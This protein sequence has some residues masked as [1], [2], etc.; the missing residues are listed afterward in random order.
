MPTTSRPCSGI[1]G[2]VTETPPWA[3]AA[4]L[5]AG[6]AV[7][8]AIHVAVTIDQRGSRVVDAYESYWHKATG[9]LFAP[10]DLERG[11]RLLVDCGLVEE[12]QGTLYP[13][14]ELQQILAG[15]FDDVVAAIYGRAVTYQQETAD[16]S[17][18]EA[19]AELEELIPDPARRE[20]LLLALARRF[21]DTQRRLIGAIGEE[22]VVSVLRAELNGLGYP[23][24]AR[25]VRH[26]S[27]ESD[28][29]G[30]DI[31]APRIGG[32]DRL[33]EVKATTAIEGGVASIYLSRNEAEVGLRYYLDWALVLCLVTDQLRREGE[34][35][36]WLS[37]RALAPALPV[38]STA[39]RWEV[40]NLAIN[41]SEL[42][43][44]TP[45][46]VA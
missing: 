16:W 28:Q 5:P 44:G 2:V 46:A 4:G 27:L 36:G 11:Q 37:S 39:G 38:D 40:A 20:E 33:V 7:R 8:A 14:A 42:L 21:D 31:A 41:I 12:R 9:G 1:S 13:R 26:L 17:S 19:S 34:I 6:H 24:L 30:Y 22:L 45:S 23:E 3:T 35:V 10:P 29:L 18:E 15:N 25:S 32:A 43:P